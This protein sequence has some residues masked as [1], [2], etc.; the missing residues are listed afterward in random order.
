M[1][2]E[3]EMQT[4]ISEMPS[5]GADSSTADTSSASTDTSNA[6]DTSSQA[7]SEGTLKTD[8][9][10]KGK[11]TTSA[12]A[13]QND[14]EKTTETMQTQTEMDDTRFDKHPRWQEMIKQRNDERDA[15]IAAEARMKALEEFHSRQTAVQQKTQEPQRDFGTEFAKLD[16]ALEDGDVD[17]NQYRSQLAK[18]SR[19]QAQADAKSIISQEMDAIKKQQAEQVR[20]QTVKE[21]ES[22]FLADNPRFM[23]LKNAGEFDKIKKEDPYGFHDDLSAYHAFLAKEGTDKFKADLDAAVAKAVAETEEKVLAQIKAKQGAKTLGTGP[24]SAPTDDIKAAPELKDPKR[25]GGR[26]K[27]LADR[28]LHSRRGSP[29]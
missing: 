24:A 14:G 28:L 26:T 3:S 19:E 17:L 18:L 4:I 10:D 9:G 20:A 2:G 11:E 16:K 6:A 12:V 5:Q 22:R 21:R 7:T 15:R 1:P 13:T 29:G 8:G 23:E 25:F 27:V